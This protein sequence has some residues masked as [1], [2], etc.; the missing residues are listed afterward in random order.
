MTERVNFEAV[1]EVVGEQ[2]PHATNA[3]KIRNQLGRGSQSTIQNHLDVLR[4]NWLKRHQA[5]S[6]EGM[7]TPS[8]PTEM[9]QGLWVAAFDAARARVMEQ[10]AALSERA[11][12]A[13]LTLTAQ[14]EDK[15]TLGAEIERLETELEQAQAEA[16]NA[17]RG[18]GAR[19]AEVEAIA[20]ALR[21]QIVS[22]EGERTQRDAEHRV[23]LNEAQ[24][25]ITTLQGVVDRAGDRAGELR[26]ELDYERRRN[27]EL[28]GRLETLA[29]RGSGAA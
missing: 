4:A 27:Q 1:R 19:V 22:L 18:A 23:A 7:P 5:V 2:D 8:A 13:Q 24:L 9:L 14:A 26:A 3:S 21:E 17:I 25:Q 6:Q 20:T 28:V 16:S 15:L 11:A 12:A 29:A 10:L